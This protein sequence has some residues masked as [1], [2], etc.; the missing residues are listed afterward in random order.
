MTDE[1]ER[2]WKNLWH[3]ILLQHLPGATEELTNNKCQVRGRKFG[4][5]Q[6]EVGENCSVRSF[7]TYYIRV[8]KCRMRWAGHVAHMGAMRT[9]YTILVGIPTGK[10]RGKI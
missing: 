5:Q 7:I 3:E 4:L 8:I 9:A 10:L 1:L 6:Q 2:I